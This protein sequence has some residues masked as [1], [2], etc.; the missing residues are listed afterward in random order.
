MPGYVCD[1][2]GDCVV[3][4]PVADGGV[5]TDAGTDASTVTPPPDASTGSGGAS[6]GGTGPDAG[7]G[8]GGTIAKGGAGGTAGV[9]GSSG[10]R[11]GSV[12]GGVMGTGAVD[13]GTT[14]SSVPGVSAN[15]RDAG[16][17]GCRVPGRS[18]QSGGGSALALLAA[19]VT[20]ARR[21][22]RVQDS[23]HP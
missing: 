19:V 12:D 7:T 1:A 4:I 6:S 23:R 20:L 18:S 5:P 22:R 11:T 9:V 17:C 2:T 14:D 15:N 3:P 8:T 16:S 13:A 21:R 10:G